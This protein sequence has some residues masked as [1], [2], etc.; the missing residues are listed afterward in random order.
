MQELL[1]FAVKMGNVPFLPRF[2][3]DGAGAL[4][5]L[6]L[7]LKFRRNEGIQDIPAVAV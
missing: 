5:S 6:L 7:A 1:W 2:R 4:H 3:A